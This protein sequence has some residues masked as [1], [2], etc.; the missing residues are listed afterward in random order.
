M[1]GLLKTGSISLGIDFVAGRNLVPKPPTGNT[2]FFIFCF[3]NINLDKFLQMIYQ[4]I[5]KS[6]VFCI[7]FLKRE[8]R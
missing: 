2:T 8:R 6:H 7:A 5:P 4:K 3:A 1:I